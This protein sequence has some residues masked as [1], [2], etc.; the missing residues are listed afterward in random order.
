MADD[1]E[2]GAAEPR[3]EDASQPTQDA[4]PAPGWPPPPPPYASGPP[5][6]TPTGARWAGPPPVGP[7]APHWPGGAAL[8]P[9]ASSSW[10]YAP[11]PY[12]VPRQRGRGLAIAAIIMSSIALL[13]LLV[14]GGLAAWLISTAAS[15]GDAPVTG[16]VRS[17]SLGQDGRLD[18]GSLEEAVRS[19]MGHQGGQV[20]SLDCPDTPEVAQGVVSV[21][22]GE[23]DGSDW[24][25][26]VFF[27]SAG[28]NF[29]IMPM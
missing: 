18:A 24:A 12:L 13:G 23:M 20:S 21:C 8:P 28:G 9:A 15:S 4:V 19:A 17:L 16:T 25:F 1:A 10:G 5:G 29:T 26:V 2:P 14:L 27:E 11:Q 6:T 3:R 7:G 22:H